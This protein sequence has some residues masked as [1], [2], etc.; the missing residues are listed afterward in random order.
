MRVVMLPHRPVT[1]PNPHGGSA[2]TVTATFTARRG[3]YTD[4]V[5]GLRKLVHEYSNIVILGIGYATNLA[6]LLNS[7][8]NYGGDG[9]A[10]GVSMIET[11]VK[12]LV[13]SAGFLGSCSG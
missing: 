4:A 1:L 7:A 13:W 6:G 3:N 8:A 10:S 12:A 11:N 9:F 2:V 5:V